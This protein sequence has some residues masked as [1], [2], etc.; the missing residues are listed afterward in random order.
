MDLYPIAFATLV[1]RLQRELQGESVYTLSRRSWWTPE[2]GIS[3]KFEHFGMTMGTPVGPASGPHTQLAQNLVLSWLGGARFMELKTVQILDDLKIPRPCIHVPHIG[4]NVEW[5]QE[6]RVSESAHEYAKG[7]YLLHLLASER[8]PGL[9]PQM[10][11]IFDIS[12][13]YDLAGIQSEKVAHYLRTMQDATVL[14]QSLRKELPPAL[15]TWAEI[16]IPSAIS[17]SVTISTFHG[18]PADEIEAIATHLMRKYRFH[19]VVKL[20][21]TLLGYERVCHIVREQLGYQQIRLHPEPFAKDLTWP[22][23]MEMVPRLQQVAREE[24]VGFGVKFSNTLVMQSDEPPFKQGE[25]MYLSGPPLHVLALTLAHEF[26]QATQ[27][28]IPITFSAGVDAQNFP[29]LV[30]AG[31]GPITTCTDLLKV[32]GYGRLHRYLRNLEGEMKSL[33]TSDLTQFRMARAGLT[34]PQQATAYNLQRLAQQTLSDPTYHHEKNHTPPKKVD[35]PLVLFDCLTCDKCVPVCPNAANFTFPVQQGTYQPGC[36]VWQNGKWNREEGQILVVERKHQIGN[37]VDA[38]NLCGH[39][40]T[41]CP[42]DGGPYL[43]KPNLFLQKQG[44]L[45]HPERDGFWIGPD[46][47][48]ITWRKQGQIYHYQQ[49]D[50]GRERFTLPGGGVLWLKQDQPV[51]CSGSGQIDLTVVFSMRLI[52]QGL[53][54]AKAETWLPSPDL[55]ATLSA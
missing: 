11:A 1:E 33:G 6:L 28:Q 13:G 51:A 36:V 20:N 35:N 48:S 54:D 30:S 4:Y 44:F 3:L 29:A 43:V 12:V 18:C 42:E 38:C 17:N 19:T 26:A 53:S 16:D 10:D 14:L 7:W 15:R 40:D 32:R 39:C 34:D 41:W 25:D 50:D 23:L 55:Y 47:R 21:P 46:F 2:Q 37:T 9:W 45:D 22:L 31:I 8:G 27:H 52:L 5:S 24:G 49:E